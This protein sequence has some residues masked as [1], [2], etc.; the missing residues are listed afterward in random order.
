MGGVIIKQHENVL[1]INK[2]KVVII[3]SLYAVT[4]IIMFL[5]LFFSAFSVLNSVSIPVLGTNIP[6]VVFGLLVLYLGVKYYLSVSKFKTEFYRSTSEFSWSNLKRE[7]KK[8]GL[9]N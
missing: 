5:G 1:T 4:I 8:F 6:G 3:N 7:K 9:K 2:K